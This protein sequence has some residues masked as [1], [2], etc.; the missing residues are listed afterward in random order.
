MH[1]SDLLQIIGGIL[2]MAG[3]LLMANVYLNMPLQYV[4]L[5][6]LSALFRGERAKSVTNNFLWTLETPRRA[7]ISVQGLGL[8][9]VGFLLQTIGTVVA[10]TSVN[11]LLSELC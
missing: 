7:L 9:G 6:I 8:I 5:H 10:T 1:I 11:I 3:T 4:P 2:Q